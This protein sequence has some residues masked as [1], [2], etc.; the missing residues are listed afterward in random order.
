MSLLSPVATCRCSLQSLHVGRPASPPNGWN[1]SGVV[2]TN[3]PALAPAR[4]QRRAPSGW[5]PRQERG[6]GPRLHLRRKLG[7]KCWYYFLIRFRKSN[8]FVTFRIVYIIQFSK[9]LYYRYIDV[10]TNFTG[11][12]QKIDSWLEVHEFVCILDC[13]KR[14]SFLLDRSFTLQFY[15]SFWEGDI[16]WKWIKL[17]I[18]QEIDWNQ[19]SALVV[20]YLWW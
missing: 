5:R 16:I 3:A 19:F 10:Y 12:L 14:G 17:V 2:P 20:C 18:T 7:S 4:P 15:V 8:A 9:W 1:S 13:P 6:V 11:G